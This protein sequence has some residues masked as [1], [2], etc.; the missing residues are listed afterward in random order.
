M[1]VFPPINLCT[2]Y[3]KYGKW[4]FVSYEKRFFGKGNGIDLAN[5]VEIH[6]IITYKSDVFL[7]NPNS[8]LVCS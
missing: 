8:Y 5:K 1:S 2:P 3:K 4:F 6:H 7:R